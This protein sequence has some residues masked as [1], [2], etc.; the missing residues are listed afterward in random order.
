MSISIFMF[1][2]LCKEKKD[3]FKCLYHEKF[4]A[5]HNSGKFKCEE[6]TNC[7]EDQKNKYGQLFD[8]A[9]DTDINNINNVYKKIGHYG[10]HRHIHWAELFLKALD[11]YDR[12]ND[13]V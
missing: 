5:E 10:A 11:N 2:S 8:I 12:I 13:K 1:F 4:D 7:H 9:M 3:N 6:Y